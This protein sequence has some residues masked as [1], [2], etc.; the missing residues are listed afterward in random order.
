MA[1]NS[2]ETSPLNCVRTPKPTWQYGL[3]GLTGAL[4]N[5]APS[6]LSP[7]I[8]V[9]SSGRCARTSQLSATVCPVLVPPMTVKPPARRL[10]VASMPLKY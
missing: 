2:Y 5:P 9:S 6:G 3:T 4:A 1:A 7:V 10:S 8:D